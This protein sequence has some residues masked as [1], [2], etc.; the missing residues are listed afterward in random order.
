MENKEFTAKGAHINHESVNEAP[1]K[2]SRPR[3]SQIDVATG[4]SSKDFFPT[5]I[6]TSVVSP[7]VGPS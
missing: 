1:L 2:W 5:E 6:G 7:S 3:L 4:T